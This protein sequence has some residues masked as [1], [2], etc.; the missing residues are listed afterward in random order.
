MLYLA[1][2]V[3]VLSAFLLVT[4]YKNRHALS[5]VWA[6]LSYLFLFTATV[7]YFAKDSSYHD[8]VTQYFYLPAELWKRVFYLRID[9]IWLIRLLH[10]SDFS[11]HLF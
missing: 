9:R 4:N 7:L 11:A 8:I 1:A 6:L 2:F 3:I 10:I 5:L